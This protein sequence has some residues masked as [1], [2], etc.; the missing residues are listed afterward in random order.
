MSKSFFLVLLASSFLGGL[1]ACSDVE[2][3]APVCIA[4]HHPAGNESFFSSY[5][6][7]I[8]WDC[9]DADHVDLLL[10]QAD[11]IHTLLGKELPN[12]GEYVWTIADDIPD[13]KG[14]R[15][16]VRSALELDGVW[17]TSS[18]FQIL[19]KGVKSTF[20]DF[21]D[22]YAYATVQIGGQVW[23]AENFRLEGIEGKYCYFN[24]P[25]KCDQLGG[26]YTQ[27][28]A[29]ENA[30]SGWHLPSDEEWQ[31]LEAYLGMAGADLERFGAR[32]RHIHELLRVDG[33]SGFNGYFGG[34]Y[35]QCVEW[36]GHFA[37]E[38]HYWTSSVD[39]EG[40]PIV[41]ILSA[42]ALHRSST[43]CHGGCSVRYV[44]DQ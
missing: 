39:E 7:P 25:A 24:D 14:Y 30:P 40:K 41:R 36:Y 31:E 2:E 18:E 38:A 42:H 8:L 43:T 20:T 32:G 23:M 26:L 10:L 1:G 3:D 19:P 33:G 35:N 5:D 15:I 11:S 4:I 28:A 12:V 21:R 27:E 9:S 13:G 16:G 34:Y 22:G 29:L 6:C 44:K 17:Q 37:F